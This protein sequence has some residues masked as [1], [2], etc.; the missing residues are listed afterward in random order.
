MKISVLDKL[1]LCVLGSMTSMATVTL[2]QK[3]LEQLKQQLFGK[4]DSTPFKITP[5]Q[6]KNENGLKRATTGTIAFDSINLKADLVKIAILSALALGI[7]FSLFLANQNGL[8]KLF[9]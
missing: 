3:R 5:K 2:E 1:A 6:S 9:N 4:S 7:Q 8:I